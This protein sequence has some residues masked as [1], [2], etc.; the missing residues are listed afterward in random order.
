MNKLQNDSILLSQW[1][2]IKNENQKFS[3]ITMGSNKKVWWICNVA[4]DHEWQASPKDRFRG[5]GCPFCRKHR[6]VLS[7]CLLTTHPEIASQWHPTKNGDL[8]PLMIG[9]CTEKYGKIW[10]QCPI[11][12]DHEW[13]AS[14]SSRTGKRAQPPGC[15][16][17]VGKKVVLSNCLATTHPEIAS[18]W[19]PTKNGILTPYDVVSGSEKYGKIWWIGKCGHEY[20]SSIYHRIKGS[21]CSICNDSR[22][23]RYIRN[24][25]EENKIKFKSQFR[26]NSCKNKK[27]LPFDFL[28]YFKKSIKLIEFNGIQHYKNIHY[29]DRKKEDFIDLQNRDKIK[30]EWCKLKN[31]PLLVIPY[32]KIKNINNLI[33][34][35]LNK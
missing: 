22:G 27:P 16:C 33:F 3:D 7:N 11:A 23:E 5:I 8:T 25:L 13:E 28:V 30:L 24:Y 20:C 17:C 31:V 10:W 1:H 4:T 19:H 32:T 15:P 9:A 6:I 18:E 12:K 29:F 14:V 35:F 2:P 26:F 34:E 21:N